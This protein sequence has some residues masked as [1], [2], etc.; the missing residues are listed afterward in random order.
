MVFKGCF[1]VIKFWTI[2]SIYGYNFAEILPFGSHQAMQ[3]PLLQV[4]CL[5]CFLLLLIMRFCCLSFVIL[6][7]LRWLVLY[8]GLRHYQNTAHEKDYTVATVSFSSPF[9]PLTITLSK[10]LLRAARTSG[11]TSEI[12]SE[13]PFDKSTHLI[14]TFGLPSFS[15]DVG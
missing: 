3:L 13:V 12:F 5:N 2:G 15:I 11:G 4:L 9:S 6:L 8:D 10:V 14:S 7:L 1:N